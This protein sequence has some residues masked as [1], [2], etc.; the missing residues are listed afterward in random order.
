[1]VVM[2]SCYWWY[3]IFILRQRPRYGSRVMR[4]N[5]PGS[6]NLT[7]WGRDTMAAFSQTTVWNAFSWMKILEFRLKFHWSLFLRVQLT[8][9]Q[10]WF[11][12][13]LGAGQAA[14]H[15]LNQWWLVYWRIYASLGLNELNAHIKPHLRPHLIV[16]DK[17][18]LYPQCWR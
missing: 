2:E 11:R 10:H 9:F 7:H 1:M 12:E 6:L 14:S 15:Y 17:Q 5:I 3:G 4:I 13:W 18:C 8:I 16:T